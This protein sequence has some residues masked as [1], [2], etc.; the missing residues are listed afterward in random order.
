[1]KGPP[2]GKR[3]RSINA[4]SRKGSRLSI[5]LLLILTIGSAAHANRPP[6]ARMSVDVNREASPH[7]YT[8]DATNSSDSDG[9]IKTY[10]WGFEEDAG[11]NQPVAQYSFSTRGTHEVRLVVIDDGG[12]STTL[13]RRVYVTDVSAAPE[14]AS[15]RQGLPSRGSTDGSYWKVLGP[16]A[17]VGAFALIVFALFRFKRKPQMPDWRRFEYKVAARFRKDGWHTDVSPAQKD[18]GYDVFLIRNGRAAVVE[19][20]YWQSAGNVGVKDLRALLG[21]VTDLSGVSK[22]FF[23]TTS[24]FTRD[25][26]AFAAGKSN[27]ELVNGARLKRWMRS[28][29]QLEDA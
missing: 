18:G 29:L 28:S 14:T 10:A 22:G 19:C 12:A 21:T 13:T 20:K 4:S 27:L 24:D 25:A 1:M 8:F 26:Q 2:S 15:T 7:V 11:S 9:E 3:M 16:L 23:V 5:C 6:V 17:A